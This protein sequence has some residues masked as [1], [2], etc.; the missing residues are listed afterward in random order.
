MRLYPIVPMLL[1]VVSFTP[2]LGAGEAEPVGPEAKPVRIITL[3]EAQEMAV[4]NHTS[5]RNLDETLYQA[6]MGIYQA[7]TMLLPNLS[8]NASVTR[9]QREVS[10]SLPMPEGQPPVEIDIQDLW[11]RNFGLSVN[12][13]LF[14]PRTI[15]LIKL[16]YDEYERQQLHD[17]IQRNE[18]LFAVTSAYYQ[19][20]SMDE[21][22]EVAKENLAMTDEFLKHTEALLAAGQATQID[23]TRAQIQ[24][25]DAEKEVANAEDAKKKAM[26]ALKHLIAE[27]EP[28]AVAGPE[29][30]K[31]VVGDMEAL[32]KQAVSDRIEL[33]QAAVSKVMA[34]RWRKETLTKFLPVFDVTYSW[35][36]ASAEGFTGANTNWVL[37]FGAKWDLFPGGS[38]IVEYKI[39][40]SEARVVDNTVEQITRD[41]YQQVELNYLDAEQRKRNVDI[42]DRQVALAEKNH[43]MVS[44]QF[45]AGLITSLDVI[46]AATKLSNQRILRVFERL[47]YDLA[48]L[49]LKKNLGEYHSLAT[50]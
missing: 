32:K 12:L 11:A 10:V 39:R 40:Q 31:P 47:Q 38:R 17:R 14:N 24:K 4:Q 29:Q 46:D 18:L 26:V 16:A 36:W 33:K 34:D 43:Y 2:P 48:I 22:I 20:Y 30:V 15:P 45:Q 27:D 21:M 35:S 8:A 23:V 37:I 6:D 1:V 7:W 41:I 28:F 5:F 25:V 3:K 42:A 49:K 50:R 44:R 13:T 19:A 9:N